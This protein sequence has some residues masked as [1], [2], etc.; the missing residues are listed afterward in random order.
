MAGGPI[1]NRHCNTDVAVVSMRG[2]CLLS[3]ENPVIAVKPRHGLC[4]ACVAAGLRFG[5][6]PCADLFPFRQRHNKSPALLLGS[7]S[8]DVAS[9]ERIVGR[10]GNADRTIDTRQLFHDGHIV[11][12]TKTRPAIFGWNQ[13]TEKPELPESLKNVDRKNL[14]FVPLHDMRTNFLLGEFPHDTFYLEQFLTEAELHITSATFRQL[15]RS[16]SRSCRNRHTD[17]GFRI[18]PTL[19]YGQMMTNKKDSM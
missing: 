14:F 1:G 9:A 17:I 11:R 15:V 13:H 18:S 19:R 7:A 5:E 16:L 10:H 8:V 4:T 12:I 3:V 2:E 6:T